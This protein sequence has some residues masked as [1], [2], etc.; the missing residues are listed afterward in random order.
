MGEKS[1]RGQE[2]GEK[3]AKKQR[4]EGK[5][6]ITQLMNREGEIVKN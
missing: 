6:E 3:R 5:I 4:K 2:I 1:R